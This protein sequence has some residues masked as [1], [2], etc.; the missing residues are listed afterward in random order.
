MAVEAG[1]RVR[2]KDRGKEDFTP[3]EWVGQEGTVAAVRDGGGMLPVSVHLD[4]DRFATFFAVE[5]LEVL[6]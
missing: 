4:G 3:Q 1:A 5:E 2:I 6:S